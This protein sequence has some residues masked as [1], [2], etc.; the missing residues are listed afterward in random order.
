MKRIV[1][2]IYED[3]TKAPVDDMQTVVSYVH[4]FYL[5]QNLRAAAAD[6]QYDWVAHGKAMEQRKATILKKKATKR[7]NARNPR[8]EFAK[9]AD[10]KKVLLAFKKEYERTEGKSHG[11]KAAACK[12]FLIDPATLKPILDQT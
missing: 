1:A 5:Q 3:G 10:A 11:W 6:T 7:T 9:R 2:V 4:A 8:N 12:K